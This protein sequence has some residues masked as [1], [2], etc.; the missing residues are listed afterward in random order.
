[1]FQIFEDKDTRTLILSGVFVGFI[2]THTKQLIKSELHFILI[3][4]DLEK[5][6][7]TVLEM[8]Q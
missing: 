6:I 7:I 8:K 3:F 1:M 2:R 5:R 4:S